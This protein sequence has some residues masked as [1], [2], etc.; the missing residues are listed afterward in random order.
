VAANTAVITELQESKEGLRV[1]GQHGLQ[2]EL[3]ASHTLS[4]KKEKKKKKKGGGR[5]DG[6]AQ[7]VEHLPSKEQ[8]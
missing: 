4:K 1:P 6:V 3:Q 2:R 8:P 5:G 7:V